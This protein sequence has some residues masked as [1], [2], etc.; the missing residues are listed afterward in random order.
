MIPLVA[1][2][3]LMVGG[4]RREAIVVAPAPPVIRWER[5]FEEAQKKARRSGKPIMV[6][7]W[8]EWCGWC[9]RLNRTT[10]LEPDVVRRS[11]DFVAVKIDTEGS[12]RE[13]EITHRYEVSSLPTILFLSPEGRELRRVSSFQSGYQFPFTMQEALETGRNV[14]AWENALARNPDDAEALAGLGAHLYEVGAREAQ[15]QSLDEARELLTRAIAR[16]A[17]SPLEE[18]RRSR[19]PRS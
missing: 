15:Q 6:D 16:D 17:D 10:Y 4:A 19:M 18:R 3:L 11:Q 12:K 7:F 9:D 8:A 13:T 5:S 1:V 2:S 14:I